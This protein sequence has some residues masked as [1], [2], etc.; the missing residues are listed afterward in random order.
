MTQRVHVIGGGLAGSEADMLQL[1]TF[2]RAK[3]G[4][5]MDQLRSQMIALR[6]RMSRMELRAPL[7]ST[8]PSVIEGYQGTDVV[9]SE[10]EQQVGQLHQPVP[11]PQVRGGL[12]ARMKRHQVADLGPQRHQ[13]LAL[14]AAIQLLQLGRG[15][16]ASVVTQGGFQSI[17][18][19]V[20]RVQIFTL[21]NIETGQPNMAPYSVPL[22]QPGKAV[23]L[24]QIVQ[25]TVNLRTTLDLVHLQHGRKTIR[26]T[27]IPYRLATL[28]GLQHRQ[29]LAQAL[30]ITSHDL[31]IQCQ[32]S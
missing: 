4:T 26:Q 28:Y 18:L 9:I 1:N 11:A 8:V 6:E 20:N 25:V 10:Q 7:D 16:L 32:L 2:D 24:R 22:L 14:E 27:T 5:Q 17:Q 3:L 30:H 29:D 12:A 19:L 15:V 21:L 23:L 31:V 13:Q